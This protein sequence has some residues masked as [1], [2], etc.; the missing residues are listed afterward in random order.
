MHFE[1]TLSSPSVVD[2]DVKVRSVSVPPESCL[3]FTFVIYPNRDRYTSTPV[4]TVG[5]ST[6]TTD[7]PKNHRTAHCIRLYLLLK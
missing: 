6:R 1:R 4:Q 2:Y 5:D 7:L 3:G